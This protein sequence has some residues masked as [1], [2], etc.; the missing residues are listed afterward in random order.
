MAM[1]LV[2]TNINHN[3]EV[4]SASSKNEYQKISGGKARPAN[5]ADKLTANYELNV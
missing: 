5:E 4:Y 3:P 1:H 2:S